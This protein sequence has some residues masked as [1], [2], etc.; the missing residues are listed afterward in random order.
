MNADKRGLITIALS[1]FIRVHLRP[2]LPFPDFFSNVFRRLMARLCRRQDRRRH[3]LAW[4]SL[5][6]A[7]FAK[8]STGFAG[9]PHQPARAVCSGP[10]IAAARA[11]DGSCRGAFEVIDVSPGAFE[12]R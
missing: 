2:N 3:Q 8:D 7:Q 11:R 5:P 1:A 6:A 9:S 4:P 10:A 12:Q